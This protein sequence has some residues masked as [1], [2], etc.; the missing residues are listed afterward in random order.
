MGRREQGRTWWR[1]FV[2]VA[3]TKFI[4]IANLVQAIRANVLGVERFAKTM[5]VSKTTHRL[6]L[7]WS[8]C[9]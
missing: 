4:K 6:V 7:E 2:F 8:T 1:T 9:K 3:L 5:K